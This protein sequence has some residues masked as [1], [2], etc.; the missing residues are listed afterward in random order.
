MGTDWR[1]FGRLLAWNVCVRPTRYHSGNRL[2]VCYSVWSLA[3][4]SDYMRVSIVI[5]AYNVQDYIAECVVSAC[6]QSH[7]D[8][9]VIVVDDGSTDETPKVLADLSRHYGG[10][11]VLDRLDNTGG[12]GAPRNRGIDIATGEFIIFLD[13]DDVLP[14][15]AARVMMTAADVNDADIVVGKRT[16]FRGAKRW[17]PASHARLYQQLA[18]RR[19][20][21]LNCPDLFHMLGPS[22]KLIRRQVLIEHDIRFPLGLT[23]GEDHLFSIKA[24]LYSRRILPIP[25]TVYD[26]RMLP[27]SASNTLNDRGIRSYAT[28][29]RDILAFFEDAGL[30]EL[31]REYERRRIQWD[32][33][34]FAKSAVLDGAEGRLAVLEHVRD[35]LA[36]FNPAVIRE[37]D[38][39]L[40][41][42]ADLLC[43]GA[44]R[45]YV[46]L[47]TYDSRRELAT[48]AQEWVSQTQRA[49]VKGKL[50]E[51]IERR[52][53]DVF[54][55]YLPVKQNK[56]V[57]APAFRDHGNV[58]AVRSAL[59]ASGADAE[60][61]IVRHPERTWKRQVR[62]AY[63]LATARVTVLE[64][65]YSPLYGMPRKPDQEVVQLWHGAGAFKR[66][67]LSAQGHTDSNDREFEQRAHAR[68]TKVIVSAEAV[69]EHYAEAFGCSPEKI[70]PLG[71]PR[72][73]VLFGAGAR[74][75]LANRAYARCPELRR[76]KVI[77]YLPTFRGS[78]RLRRVVPLD[79]DISFMADLPPEYVLAIKPHPEMRNT[80]F[81]V[82]PE[83]ADRVSIVDHDLP[84]NELLAV[85][86]ILVT[87]YSSV[88]FEFAALGRPMI[89]YAPDLESYH[90]ERGFYWD[91]EKFVPGP[92][93]STTREIA[94]VI[95]DGQLDG[96]RVRAF[97]ARFHQYRDGCAAARVVEQVVL[98]ILTG[99]AAPPV[100]H[101]A[102][103]VLPEQVAA[104][105]D[106]EPEDQDVQPPVSTS[107]I[108]T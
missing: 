40:R 5:P 65:Y 69:R 15:N 72:S 14:P 51:D 74:V 9:E 90:G 98:P 63:H 91:Y 73:D 93:V 85:T 71:F 19:P 49:L 61:V 100:R 57:F 70:L 30:Q 28:A 82:P 45:R 77:A 34:R 25:D 86:D 92:L 22:A 75:R 10:R 46:A 96:E 41:L 53:L 26:Y 50:S 104:L 4:T 37:L 2:R 94:S 84:A 18:A 55:R 24:F 87:D 54:G 99:E 64:S 62:R 79:F 101:S 83:L 81:D 78:P 106:D 7:E 31:K 89:F 21:V 16:S 32:V 105:V 56:V 95:R 67:G 29:L 6:G 44:F 107:S 88:I 108:G 66:F 11:L 102:P 60:H 3:P 58:S 103:D 13:A 17:V 38:S 76:R 35:A 43:K 20:T 68:Y 52:M 47:E 27:T 42:K 59:V 36:L 48:K 23:Y 1:R 39:R 33:L 12:P 8:V 80:A 97:A